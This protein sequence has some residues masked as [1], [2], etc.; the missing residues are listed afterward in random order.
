MAKYVFLNVPAHGHV[1]PTLPIVQELVRRG[2]EVSY[3]LTEG[4]REAVEATGAIFHG[5]ESNMRDKMVIAKLAEREASTSPSQMPFAKTAGFFRQMVDEARQLPP[6]IIDRIRAEQPDVIVYGFMCAWAK[7][8]V[9]ELQVPAITIRAS[10]AANEHFNILS[11]VMQKMMQ[12]FPG[13]RERPEMLK[14][15]MEG[16]GGP[17]TN[18]FAEFSNLFRN[19]EQLNIVIMPK[20]FQPAAETFDDRYVFVGSSIL[21]RHEATDFPFDRLNTDQPLLYI[22]LG[23]VAVPQPEFFKLCF[24]AFAGQ[25]WQVVLSIGKVLDPT[26][27][28]PAPD[29]FLLSPYVPQLDILPRTHIFVTHAGA[30]SV[31]ESMYY[32]VPMVLIPQQPEQQIHA[33]RIVEMGLGIMLA[34]DAMSATTLREAVE[35]IAHDPAYRNRMQKMQQVTR[36]GG[37]YERAADAIIQFTQVLVRA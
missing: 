33:Q 7:T 15:M 8:V 5:Y 19:E 24:D 26:M 34:K 18:P 22:S 25:P 37:G 10:F 36:A 30:N 31:I 32:G 4:F 35:R 28:G 20:E 23:S 16:Q 17:S 12:Q 6:G 11:L 27:L 21:P 14:A 3:Y 29:N 2:E 1:N 9:Q 13:M